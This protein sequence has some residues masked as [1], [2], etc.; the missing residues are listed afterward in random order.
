M[1]DRNEKEKSLI[2]AIKVLQGGVNFYEEALGKISDARIK[3]VFKKMAAHKRTAIDAL[4]P[5]VAGDYMHTEHKSDCIVKTRQLY[6]KLASIISG[7]KQYTYAYQLEE[8]EDRVL[9]ALDDALA[10]RQSAECVAKLRPV[11]EDAQQVHDLMKALQ[12]QLA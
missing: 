12:E 7:N 8:V 5:F 9:D 6:T 11:R 2:D 4:E 3:L 10:E 1:S